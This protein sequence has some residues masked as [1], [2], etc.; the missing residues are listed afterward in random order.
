VYSWDGPQR[1]S[2]AWIT[3]R[4]MF[5]NA[6]GFGGYVDIPLAAGK[7]AIWFLVTD[8]SGTKN[9]GAD[10]HADLN[11]DVAGKGQEIWLLEGDCAVY[12]SQPALSYGNLTFAN[13]HWLTGATL[14]WPGVP[15]AGASYKLFYAAN[16]GLVA[17]SDATSGLTG[18]TGSFTLTPAPLS[19]AIRQKYPH[20][21]GATG[22]QLSAADAAKAA[23]M[24]SSQFGIAQYD[25]SGNLVQVTSLQTAGMLDDV[26]AARASKMDLG[27]SFNVVGMPTF[28]VWAPTAKN[29]SLNMYASA[30][31]ATPTTV[32]MKRDDASGVW[33]YSANEFRQ[34]NRIWYTYTVQVLSRWANNTIVTNTVTDPYS[35]SLNANSTRSFAADLD[36]RELKPSGWDGQPIPKLDAPTDIAL[37]EL[38]IRDFSASDQTVPAQHR[39]KYLAFTDGQSNGMRHLKSLQKAGMTHVHLLPSFDLASINEAGCV[40]SGYPERGGRFERPAGRRGEGG[41]QRL[42]QLGL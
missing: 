29:V 35:L 21:A 19:D 30:D 7:S 37:Y 31:A 38:H 23:Q 3:D 11:A 9:C 32:P 34:S 10:Q 16:G 22:L 14:A 2:S 27:V 36:S 12:N 13:A 17:T 20:L 39:G 8:G 25:A 26:F 18:A 6:D 42:L 4:F 5:T 15:A 41:G 33:S 1:P 40:S 24:A 28:R